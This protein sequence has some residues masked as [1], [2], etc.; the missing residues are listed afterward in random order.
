MNTAGNSNR[1]L[2]ENISVGEKI[3]TGLLRL[4]IPPHP[5]NEKAADYLRVKVGQNNPV[6]AWIAVRSD[7]LINESR[8]TEYSLQKSP[9][10]S[11]LGLVSNGSQNLR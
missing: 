11:A 4:L 1:D 6:I 7:S 2:N 3:V 5:D 9:T 8:V 10:R